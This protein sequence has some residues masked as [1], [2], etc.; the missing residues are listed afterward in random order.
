[1][2]DGS[3]GSDQRSQEIEK[4][5]DRQVSGA[6]AL[7]GT[8][9]AL[10]IAP[11]NMAEMFEFAK[12]MAISGPCV[13]PSFRGNPGA[14]LA[15][16][17]QAFRT[18]ADPFA[19]ANK[20]YI[21]KNRAGDEQIAY[22]AQYIHAVLNT[23]GKLARR[24]RPTYSGEGAKRKCKIIG[25]VV[26]E[27]E[28]LDYES[29][30]IEAIPVK[31]SPLWTGDPDQQ[32]FYYSTRAWGRKHLP[33]VLLGMY[34]PDEIRGEVIDIT[35]GVTEPR[36]RPEDY[37][38]ALA[39]DPE[40]EQTETQPRFEVFDSVGEAHEYETEMEALEALLAL[41]GEARS[42]RSVEGLGESN[43]TLAH[44]PVI[45]AAYKDMKE[46]LSNPNPGNR[47]DRTAAGAQ[48]QIVPARGV[49]DTAD[50][51]RTEHPEG[52]SLSSTPSERRSPSPAISQTE[53][54]RD[55]AK[56]V[57]HAPRDE[58]FWSQKKY[59][60]PETSKPKELLYYLGQ[61]LRQCRDQFDINGLEADNAVRF[62]NL[63]GIDHREAT[64]MIAQR[65]KEI[66][67][68]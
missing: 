33:E 41:I 17:L 25:Y 60:L 52:E 51:G 66:G 37:A 22:E 23:S 56:S 9:G 6:I 5:I 61:Y 48:P 2:P 53:R 18:G 43:P 44:Y 24:L 31:N 32:L 34:T 39:R 50:Q 8:G 67:H 4:R 7:S 47:Q 12:L 28:P 45:I 63:L 30:S 68:S 20:A 15:L 21:T 58:A 59:V 29:P 42:L 65:R 14:C 38:M 26:G 16:A 40:P 55:A 57:A 27:D 64:E 62:S 54:P 1:M 36:P 35:P 11:T 49:T 10:A 46:A 19:V 3:N 13:R